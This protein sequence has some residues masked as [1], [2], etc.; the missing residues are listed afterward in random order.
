MIIQ[1]FKAHGAG[2]ITLSTKPDN[3]NALH[4][5]KEYG[6]RENGDMNDDEIVLKL[7]IK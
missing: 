1:Y 5:Y 6:F 4:I 7:K 3:Y 2:E